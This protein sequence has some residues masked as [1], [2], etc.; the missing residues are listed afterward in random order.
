M[1]AAIPMHMFE[2]R[3][4]PWL[5]PIGEGAGKGKGW[6]SQQKHSNGDKPAAEYAAPQL[7]GKKPV[8]QAFASCMSLQP[9]LG[10]CDGSCLD[11]VQQQ[12]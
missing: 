6:L 3:E 11:T 4:F 8:R 7:P 1:T 10:S 9:G 5:R 12:S 2:W